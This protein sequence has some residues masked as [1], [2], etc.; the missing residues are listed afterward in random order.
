MR[1]LS[2]LSLRR[3]TVFP[4][5]SAF[6]G[7]YFYPR[8]PCGERLMAFCVD[9]LKSTYFYP[10]SPCGERLMFPVVFYLEN[11]FLSTLSLRRATCGR[12]VGLPV[13]GHFYPRSPCG[14]RRSNG[15]NHYSYI[16]ISIHALLAES[17]SVNFWISFPTLYFYPRSP[18]G[19]RHQNIKK[20]PC[21]TLISIH[22]LLA[23]SDW[24]VPLLGIK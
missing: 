6:Q 15:G 20:S 21:K 19:E 8:S 11:V 16:R 24:I 7:L 18:C 23:E 1:F 12:R 13:A 9:Y 22:A 5:G 17:D 14:E 2:T 10:R 4:L 3:A